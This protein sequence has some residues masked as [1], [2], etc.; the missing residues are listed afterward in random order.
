LD[1]A[2]G[3][4]DG[5]SDFRIFNY[6]NHNLKNL[7]FKKVDLWDAISPKFGLIRFKGLPNY[8]S[9][10]SGG[11]SLVRVISLWVCLYRSD[12]KGGT[13]ADVVTKLSLVT[14]SFALS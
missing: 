1:V 6:H 12:K 4:L 9:L 14:E 11:G 5:S 2:T 13:N 10:T 8:N 3:A 7:N